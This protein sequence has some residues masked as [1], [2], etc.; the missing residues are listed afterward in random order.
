MIRSG[1]FSP[2]RGSGDRPASIPDQPSP[3]SREAPCRDAEVITSAR[4]GTTPRSC[5]A[6]CPRLDPA[7]RGD[8]RPAGDTARRRAAVSTN[9]S[10]VC[11]RRWSNV[12]LL[13]VDPSLDWNLPAGTGGSVQPEDGAS[14]GSS[15]LGK[16]D[17]TIIANGDVPFELGTRY[18]DSH[19][20]SVSRLELL[21]GLGRT[22]RAGSTTHTAG[23]AG[24]PPASPP[25]PP[26]A[27]AR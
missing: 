21:T 14:L 4:R 19:A 1:C 12:V 11:R 9:R 2:R 16:S 15:E 24:S 6:G 3:A 18:C 23:S 8:F 13:G 7:R 25:T 26:D 5:C 22:R 20:Q 27:R 17:L 10:R